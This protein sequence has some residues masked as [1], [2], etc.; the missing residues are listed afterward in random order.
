MEE[1]KLIKKIAMSD[2]GLMYKWKERNMICD[3]ELLLN[4]VI[5]NRI[6]LLLKDP[7][8]SY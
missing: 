2:E 1:I 6:K 7:L 3:V 4:S 5:H 8:N